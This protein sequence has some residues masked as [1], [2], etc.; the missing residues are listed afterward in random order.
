MPKSLVRYQQTGDLHFVTFSCYHRQPHLG[1]PA[2]VSM[3][4]R[5]SGVAAPRKLHTNR[6]TL[7]CKR[8]T[9]ACRVICGVLAPRRQG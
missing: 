2:A 8:Q 3:I 4:A 7:W 5:A 9:N 1:S 6:L